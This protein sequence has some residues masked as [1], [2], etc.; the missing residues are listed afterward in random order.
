[1]GGQ[2]S[3]EAD[4]EIE[5]ERKWVFIS[6]DPLSLDEL[7]KMVSDP[8]CG[9][10]TTFSGTTRDNFEGKKA[11]EP[12]ALKEMDRILQEVLEGACGKGVR[13]V[14]CAHRLGVVPLAEASVL[15]AVASEHRPEGF[16]AC[17][18]IIDTLKAKVP[19]WKKEIYAD[20]ET[21][22]ANKEWD[23]THS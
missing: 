11:Y 21:W 15:I 8:A 17:R 12:M 7:M 16:A 14:A 13:R 6:H 4:A 19:I 3:A 2:V 9:A 1:M 18:Y 20:G 22:K 23:P 10:I 5:G